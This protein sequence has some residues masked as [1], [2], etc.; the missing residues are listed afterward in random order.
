MRDNLP[1]A[2]SIECLDLI[3][4]LYRSAMSYLSGEDPNTESSQCST[5]VEVGN[6]I[7][8]L[9]HLFPYKHRFE[10]MTSVHLIQT[11]F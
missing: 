10:E 11:T 3:E 5:T 7:P 9:F 8:N 1:I 4:E 6:E 2:Y